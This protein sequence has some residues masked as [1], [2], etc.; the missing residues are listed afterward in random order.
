M[1]TTSGEKA[2]FRKGQKAI[3]L[4]INTLGLT[5]K[6]IFFRDI[7]FQQKHQAIL[8]AFIDKASYLDRTEGEEVTKE[9]AVKTREF[10]DMLDFIK[11]SFNWKEGKYTASLYVQET[12]LSK[13]HVE[14][15]GFV[16]TKNHI[17]LLEKNIE[18]TQEYLKD[19]ILHKGI[20]QEEKSKHFWHWANPSFYRV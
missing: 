16:L 10:L 5:E 11:T 18:V 8:S 7:S 6:K 2:E 20:K 13:L 19:V 12:S 15:Y 14:H 1:T 17:E 4:K 3:A 9:K